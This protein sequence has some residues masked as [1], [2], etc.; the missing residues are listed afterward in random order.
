MKS[1]TYSILVL[2][3]L[4][5]FNSQAQPILDSNYFNS[6]K[7]KH[8]LNLPNW[9]PYTKKYIGVSHIPDVDKGLRFDLSVFPG[10]YRRK[11]DVPNVFF[12]S[13][14]HPWEASPN[15][16]YFSF[17]HELEWKDRVYTDISYSLMD[18]KSRLVR[19]EC[20][21]NTDIAQS[22]VLHM[23]SSIHFPSIK[24]Y[25]PN[26]PIEFSTIK[27]PDYAVWI[28]GLDYQDLQ[29][30]TPRPQDQLG[31]DGKLRG[32][33]R[34]HGL[35]NGSGIG[36]GFGNDIND[37]VLY[38]VKLKNDIQDAILWLRY[39]LDE[40]QTTILKLEGIANK[41]LKLSGN[42]D[43]KI[44][45]IKLDELKPGSYGLEMVSREKT[46]IVIDGFTVVREGDVKSI[47]V[48]A[49]DWNYTPQIIE[50]PVKNSVILKYENT[51]NYYGL[52]WD[53]DGYQLRQ[54]HYKDLSDDFKQNVNGHV[55]TEFS[56]GTNGHFTNV[57]LRPITIAPNS[58]LTV[59]G[60]VCT[61]TKAEVESILKKKMSSAEAIKIY[62]KAR[63][64]L[65]AYD[66][67]PAGERYIFSNQRMAATTITNVVYPVYTQR[68]YIR[69]H[70]PGR[71]WDCLYT[72]DAGFIGIG[73]AQQDVRRGIESLNAYVNETDEQSAF[74]H[75]GTPLPVQHY[76]FQELWN[77][78]QSEEFLKNYY[79]KL[80]RYYEF[81]SGK[82]PSSTTRMNSNLIRTWDYFY[83]SGGWDDYPPQHHLREHSELYKNVTPVVSTA[84]CI[85]IAKILQMAAS[86]L[87]L[88]KDS[89]EYDT[90]IN[91]MS[92]A[93]Q[94]NSWD[95]ESGYYGYVVHDASG[96]AQEIMKFEGKT[97]YNM[98]LG[99]VSPLLAG[100]CTDEQKEKL[101]KHLKTKGEI[102]SDVGLSAVDQT[103]PYYSNE[104][105]WNGTVWMPHQWFMW[106][107]MLDFGEADF[108]FKIAD[109][110]LNLWKK[111]VESTYN[112]SEH[113]V[114]ESG[115]GAGW[116]QF[117]G[118]STPVL[119]WFN[120]Y[121]QQGTL[122]TGFNAWV[123][124]K[125]FDSTNSSL[126]AKL[127]VSGD[128]GDDFSMVVCLNPE[129]SYQVSWNSKPISHKEISKGTLSIVAPLTS[130]VGVLKVEKVVR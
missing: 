25:N 92:K 71:W 47:E 74:I 38:G 115:R 125:K 40:G 42:G 23:M 19:I 103:A 101:L 3:I 73:L 110:A 112:C 59:N 78:T 27:L 33:I 4:F 96:N 28:D 97:N 98:G 53:Y 35:V 2:T 10:F 15:L 116:H 86:H 58:S 52:Y 55:S 69:H 21:N 127:K 81:I 88:K 104:G 36:N 83:N 8:D 31:Y 29:F 62:E 84:H 65:Y 122:T 20:V 30:A 14:F 82:N 102:W 79:P 18:E 16:E 120:A 129:F 67:T 61:G 114:I 124:E 126:S 41:T 5:T 6:L 105:Y 13:G 17:R 119:S 49:V 95:E 80:K 46:S 34:D 130:E 12:E 9:G 93:L 48:K 100:I 111:E 87:K 60:V 1:F 123:L 121:Y 89:K 64:Y 57:F 54:W 24:E 43:F 11:V 68:Q 128:K 72:W 51:D 77:A 107:T 39:K 85:R 70:A 113:F 90:D 109:T 99:G 22:I 7:Y 91:L 50:G 118:L 44:E 63:E 45:Q 56:N 117:S 76:L 106:K 94:D 26:T 66:V 108:A 37:R 75:H 32:E